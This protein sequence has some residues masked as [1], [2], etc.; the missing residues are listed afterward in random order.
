MNIL[1]MNLSHKAY[2]VKS[3][4]LMVDVASYSQNIADLHKIDW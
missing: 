2:F 1:F 4:V 3:Y